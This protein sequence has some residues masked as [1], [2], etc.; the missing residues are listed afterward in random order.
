MAKYYY[1]RYTVN[2]STSYE[3]H[4]YNLAPYTYYPPNEITSGY[5]YDVVSGDAGLSGYSGYGIDARSGYYM[6]GSYQSTTVENSLGQTF[7]T[8]QSAD[9]IFRR[10]NVDIPAVY[11]IESEYQGLTPETRY[12]QGSYVGTTTGSYSYKTNNASDGTYW[13]VRGNSST[14][15]YRGT[16]VDE[17]VAEDGAYPSNNVSGSYWYVKDR[18]A[19]PELTVKVGGALKTSDDGW[20]KVGGTLKQIEQI[21]VKVNGTIKEV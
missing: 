11:A 17:I 13:W 20:V 5:S 12:E 14:Y 4:Y 15:Y 10:T 8:L 7:Y 19:F 21:W 2:S 18:K 3:W 9:R 16:Y 6:T 1:K